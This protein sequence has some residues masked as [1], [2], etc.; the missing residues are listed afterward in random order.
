MLPFVYE[1]AEDIPAALGLA[2][3]FLD[4]GAIPQFLAGGTTLLDLMKLNVL[5][6]PVVIDINDLAEQHSEIDLSGNR[7]RLGAFVKMA[8]AVA[9]AQLRQRLPVL[10]QSLELAASMQLRN[11]ATLGGNVLQRTRCNY[12]R[13]PAIRNCNK[14]F[15]GTGCAAMTGVNRKHA[16]LGVSDSCIATYPGDFAQALIALDASLEL[17]G[18]GGRRIVSFDQLHRLP[19]NTPQI[20][21]NLRPGE[22]IAAFEI[23]SAPWM[24]RSLYLKIRDRQSYE[25]ALVSAA[26][27]LDMQDNKVREARIALGG[28]ATKPWRAREAESVLA[29]QQLD[30]AN[31]QRAAEAAVKGA[32]VRDQNAYKVELTRRT[33]VRAL[34]EAAT[35]KV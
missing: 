1:R 13:D 20:E 5:Q 11:M 18:P 8:D 16:I 27:A 19:A 10:V 30:G 3:S 21:S 29:G 9:N 4:K 25:F 22:V 15:P 6:P 34:R 31:A 2:R 7:L 24:A 26:V 23:P 17:W 33:L 28:I 35:L 32:Q 12:F 14:R